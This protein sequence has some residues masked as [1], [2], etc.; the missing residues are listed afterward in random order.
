VLEWRIPK[1][2]TGLRGPRSQGGMDG[3]DSSGWQ[4]Q[5][6]AGSSV[7]DTKGHWWRTSSSAMVGGSQGWKGGAVGGVSRSPD[8]RGV[9]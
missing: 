7:E 3:A 2:G 5:R 4:C 8:R 1:L 6:A 9:A